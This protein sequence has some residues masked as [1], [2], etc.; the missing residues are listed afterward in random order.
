MRNYFVAIFSQAIFLPQKLW[1][2]FS[3]EKFCHNF[4]GKFE[5]RIKIA[6]TLKTKV[7]VVSICQCWRN[8]IK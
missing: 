7:L 2:F 4:C 8:P 5:N 6:T 1:Q 3:L